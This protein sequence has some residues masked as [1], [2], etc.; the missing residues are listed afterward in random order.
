MVEYA[1]ELKVNVMRLTEQA[2]RP[3]TENLGRQAK[4]GTMRSS[5]TA[6]AARTDNADGPIIDATEHS[7]A[8]PGRRGATR[9]CEPVG[10]GMHAAAGLE[11]LSAAAADVPAS[12]RLAAGASLFAAASRPRLRQGILAMLA[13]QHAMQAVELLLEPGGPARRWRIAAEA[14]ISAALAGM[15]REVLRAQRWEGHPLL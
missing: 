6:H 8:S 4:A 14:G 1:T 5:K 13:A 12:S 9:A 3:G 2:R 15:L 11:V 10:L 7:F